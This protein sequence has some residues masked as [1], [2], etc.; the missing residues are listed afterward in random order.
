M[1]VFDFVI[2]GAGSAGAVLATRLSENKKYKVL[3]IEAGGND[4][5]PWLH[6]PIGVGKTLTD[7]RFIWNFQTEPEKELN[8]RNILWPRGK[9][10]G[11]SSSINGMLYVK[12]APHR[13][14]EWRDGNNPGWG[15]NEL[16]P[17]F[18]KLE[19]RR[20]SNHPDRGIGG[21][22]KIS[23]GSYR[24]KLS[25]AFFQ[26]CV[27]VGAKPNKD[28]N[29]NFDGV[30]WL[31]YS[32]KNGLRCSTSSTYLKIAKKNKNLKIITNA[33]V[34]KIIF[35]GKKAVGVIYNKDNF[36]KEI[37]IRGEVIL[38]AGSINSPKI[39]ELS[40]IGQGPLLKSHGI[41][42]LSDIKG[43]GE[44]LTDHLQTRLTYETDLKVTVNDILNNKFRGALEALRYIVRRDGLMSIASA[45][46]HALMRSENSK[47]Y[48]DL[49]V[50]IMLISGNNRYSRKKNHGMDSFSGFSL[51]VFPLYPSSRGATHLRSNN[52]RDNPI[53]KANY[54]STPDD[55]NLTIKGLRLVRK[56][57][58]Q[59]SIC[60]YIVREV[61]PGRNVEDDQGLLNFARETG[62][63]SWHSISTCRMGKGR[64]NVVDYDLKVFGIENLRVV[65]SSIMPCMPSSN[66]NA[67]SIVIGEKGADII[68]KNTK[69]K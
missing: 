65:D 58:N 32:T 60:P 64:D 49:K 34:E 46:V 20:E 14:D 55:R 18:R 19:D 47:I 63:T 28:Y 7:H 35:E 62:Q 21:P 38:S 56:I 33:E 22:I 68:L 5:H 9:V 59:K 53:I 44:N 17:Y 10:L 24:D 3:L 11:G 40:G 67:P 4:N 61:R 29:I 51:G 6:I 31:Q 12:G 15:Y 27:D 43:V 1:D 57:A 30:G 13:Y 66:T 69:T 39:L 16:L 48:P 52:F 2:V 26:A 36:S 23:S 42:V 50:Q 8:R 37:R 25:D 54:L 41:E 45:T